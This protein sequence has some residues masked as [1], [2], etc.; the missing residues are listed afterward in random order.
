MVEGVPLAAPRGEVHDRRR[1][2][3]R[4]AARTGG[5]TPDGEVRARPDAGNAGAR[6]TV[7]LIAHTTVCAELLRDRL[8]R[9][10]K[11]QVVGIDTDGRTGFQAIALLQTPPDIL[12]LDA[13]ARHAPELAEIIRSH[14]GPTRVV[15]FG[16]DE[17]PSQA[18]TWAASGAS[19]LIGRSASLNELLSI[20][21]TVADGSVSSSARL[22][23]ALLSGV[24]QLVR[25]DL[26]DPSTA[27]TSREREVAVLLADGLTNK[28]IA[29]H[30][31]IEP[32]TVKSHVHNVIRKFGVRRRAQ[33]IAQMRKSPLSGTTEL[34]ADGARIS[35][36]R[37]PG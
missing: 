26:E 8:V 1:G 20:V 22:T 4:K 35:S 36:L 21:E 2:Y 19:A 15:A 27:L 3:G 12:V 7:F 18:M 28:E 24:S 31:Q 16:V 17:V 29:S 37:S 13:G 32:G 23:E 9:S 25:P 11:F 6:Q 33:V 10:C 34:F 14:D 5:H 30:M